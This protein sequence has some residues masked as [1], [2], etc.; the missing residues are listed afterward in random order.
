MA[1]NVGFA[2]PNLDGRVTPVGRQR[3]LSALS[4][5]HSIG[6]QRRMASTAIALLL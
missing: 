5:G 4:S 1:C 3:E 2:A 6:L